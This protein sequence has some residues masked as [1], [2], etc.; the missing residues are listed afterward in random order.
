M[1]LVGITLVQKLKMAA[2]TLNRSAVDF[3]YRGYLTH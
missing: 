3:E 1:G 2:V